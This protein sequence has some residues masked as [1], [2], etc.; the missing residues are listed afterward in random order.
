MSDHTDD[1]GYC[2]GCATEIAELREE[3]KRL[4]EAALD[5]IERRVAERAKQSETIRRLRAEIES[6]TPGG[7]EFSN[8]PSACAAWVRARLA[9][10]ARLAKERNEL[11]GKLEQ[12]V[13]RPVIIDENLYIWE[14]KRGR[15]VEIFDDTENG[16]YPAV[17]IKHAVKVLRENGYL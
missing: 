13:G 16:G 14:Y 7:S 5:D 2:A 4:R 11:R 1:T 6:L 12:A 15:I 9:T 17:S 10:T 8:N 3:I